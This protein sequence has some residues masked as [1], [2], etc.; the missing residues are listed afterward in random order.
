M[1]ELPKKLFPLLLAV[2]M[3]TTATSSYTT[4][5]LNSN[6]IFVASNLTDYFLLSP[7]TSY[8]NPMRLLVL[9][10]GG[11]EIRNLP[12]SSMFRILYFTRNLTVDSLLDIALEYKI[13]FNSAIIGQDLLSPDVMPYICYLATLTRSI[14][15]PNASYKILSKLSSLGVNKLIIYGQSPIEA[16]GSILKLK[17][18]KDV[19]NYAYTQAWMKNY[20]I[21]ALTNDTSYMLIAAHYAGI[22]GGILA[23]YDP[24]AIHTFKPEWLAV[25][26][27]PITREKYPLLTY[28]YNCSTSIDGD[29]YIDVKIGLL[30]S[31]NIYSTSR[32]ITVS[33]AFPEL[34]GSWDNRGVVISMESGS[35]LAWKIAREMRRAG[36]ETF[37]LSD[38]EEARN[39]SFQTFLNT[40]IQGGLLTY[41]NLHGNIYALSPQQYG[42]PI[43]DFTDI[44]HMPPTIILTLSCETCAF[45][46][47]NNPNE[48]IAYKFIDN[49]AVS[50]IGSTSLEYGGEEYGS[51]YPEH[52]VHM[53][54]IQ[55][56]PIGEV[57]R[58]INNIKIAQGRR[59]PKLILIGDPLLTIKSKK[60]L[61][62][63][64][65]T[66]SY[67]HKYRITIKSDTAS[68]YIAVPVPSLDSQ[69]VIGNESRLHLS[70]VSYI[71]LEANKPIL[72][73][74]LTRELASWGIG[75]LK[76]GEQ[77]TVETINPNRYRI[78]TAFISVLTVSITLSALFLKF[79]QGKQIIQ[80]EPSTLP[81]VENIDELRSK[82]ISWIKNH[83]MYFK[84]RQP[85]EEEL[86]K[87]L[88]EYFNV[89]IQKDEL[90]KYILKFAIEHSI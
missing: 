47:L 30:T 8:T 56:L 64:V 38:S 46:Q 69:I 6:V 32:L 24:E 53:L 51:T 19:L 41:I 86:V 71:E 62:C 48:S 44:P 60:R 40:L 68:V 25:V 20:L 17:T 14:I 13:P 12:V 88:E 10:N 52:M 28:L 22:R 58:I 31:T 81:K 59:A 50:Y 34:Q 42:N 76:P 36:L 33:L 72:H 7:L 43:L 15:V 54:L 79:R 80:A 18:V 73:L 74:L 77:F 29:K 16:A 84:T 27:P 70:T 1:I 4:G 65:E 37:Y 49:G 85:P 61:P 78:I 63:M 35:A 5:Q 75:D 23:S 90:N 87:Y 89:K 3:M 57:V 2:V 83:Q 55:G 66:I 82:V 39:L 21:M 26:S 45:S 9:S 11:D 67:G